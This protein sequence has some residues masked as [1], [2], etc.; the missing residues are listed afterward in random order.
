M[1]ARQSLPLGEKD[2]HGRVCRASAERTYAPVSS[3]T[4]L[5]KARPRSKPEDDP[6]ILDGDVV[7][8]VSRIRIA[9]WRLFAC[10]VKSRRA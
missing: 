10:A 1:A 4:A 7:A 3:D 8:V 9:T 5:D 6:T 2:G